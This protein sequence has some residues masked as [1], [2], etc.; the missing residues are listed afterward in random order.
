VCYADKIIW[1]EMEKGDAIY[2]HRIVVNPVFKG[3][4]L[5]GEIL[6]WAI[7]HARQKGLNFI[8]MD[9]W[10][11]NPHII[12]YYKSFG[13]SVVENFTTPDSPELPLHN[14]KLA[15][16]LLQINIENLKPGSL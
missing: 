4:R 13:F 3:K 6:K 15:L 12:G 16:T 5:F 10:A 2:L 9:T 14:R 1:R 8:R 11:D 7:E